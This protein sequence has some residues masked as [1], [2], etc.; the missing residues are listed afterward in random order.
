MTR[1]NQNF[2]SLASLS[3]LSEWLESDL[4]VGTELRRQV[5]SRGGLIHNFVIKFMR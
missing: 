4:A 3:I 1:L 2:N 5:S